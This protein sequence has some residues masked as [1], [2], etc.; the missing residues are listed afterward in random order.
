MK[1]EITKQRLPGGRRTSV[2]CNFQMLESVAFLQWSNEDKISL[3]K[4]RPWPFT[5]GSSALLF[6]RP[7]DWAYEYY[8]RTFLPSDQ[9]QGCHSKERKYHLPSR[10][11][12][13]E[14]PIRGQPR[15]RS[16]L[17]LRRGSAWLLHCR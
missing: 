10:K 14:N 3:G 7:G 6:L 12:V 8:H 13:G 16:H 4:S 17:R 1:S 5:G 9:R 2:P 15:P 11:V